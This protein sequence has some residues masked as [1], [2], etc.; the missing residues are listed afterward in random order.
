MNAEE[1]MNLLE[2]DDDQPTLEQAKRSLKWPK[3]EHAI[4]AELVQLWQKGT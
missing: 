3:W 2:G 4:Q 1:L